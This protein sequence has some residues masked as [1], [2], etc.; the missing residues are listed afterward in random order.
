MSN[1][2]EVNF[3][4]WLKWF[5]IFMLSSLGFVVYYTTGLFWKVHE[6]DITYICH[7][8]I[9]VFFFFSIRAGYNTYHA[10][11]DVSKGIG[12]ALPL[13]VH[14]DE[15]EY[16]FWNCKLKKY[17][18]LNDLGWY[19]ANHLPTVGLLGTLIGIA[20]VFVF[21]GLDLNTKEGQVMAIMGIGTALF[22]T[23]I[24]NICSLMLKNQLMNLKYFM[25]EKTGKTNGT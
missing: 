15:A 6:V 8:S 1:L 5:L 25:D 4:V 20:Y 22:T 7:I 17:Y 13:T 24:A 19:V 18:R 12:R 10:C 23:I 2:K 9:I 21:T 3:G 11:I 14:C 16:N